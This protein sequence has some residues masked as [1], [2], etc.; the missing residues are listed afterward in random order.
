MKVRIDEIGEKSKRLSAEEPIA[1]YQALRDMEAHGDCSFLSPLAINI[2]VVREYDHIRVH[3]HVCT[4]VMLRCS[5]CLAETELGIESSFTMF[6]TKATPGF[7]QDEEVELAEEDLI[8]V[9]YEGDE[10]DFAPEI[11]EQVQLEIPVKPLCREDC[12]G[13]CTNCGADLNVAECGCDRRST[14]LTF[15]ALKDFKVQK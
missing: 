15:S 4:K 7:P 6:Y 9:T 13:L 1:E 14:S 3:G 8:A 5:R 2:D 12:R 11:A 10:I